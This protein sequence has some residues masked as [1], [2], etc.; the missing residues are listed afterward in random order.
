MY[1]QSVVRRV[2][3]GDEV[4]FRILFEDWAEVVYGRAYDILHDG[5]MAHEVVKR[6][7]VDVYRLTPRLRDG[8]QFDE[9]LRRLVAYQ[10]GEVALQY[11]TLNE[12]ARERDWMAIAQALDIPPEEETPPVAMKKRPVE[13]EEWEPI[14]FYPE[15][16]EAEQWYDDEEDPPTVSAVSSSNRAAVEAYLRKPA[17]AAAAL[18]GARKSAPAPVEEAPLPIRPRADKPDVQEVP[19]QQPEKKTVRSR[20]KAVKEENGAVLPFEAET[21]AVKS[22]R[23]G[24]IA[25]ASLLVAA[26]VLLAGSAVALILM[27]SGRL[28]TPSFLQEASMAVGGLWE[29]I[30]QSL[31]R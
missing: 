2:M 26:T 9:W 29:E 6:T 1:N 12:Q 5:T 28:G 21:P 31:F 30:V 16:D 7:F 8:R 10:C 4:A 3:K 14:L 18:R 20:K 23:R 25:V 11:R 15:E 27:H 17:A 13:E 22:R 19:L 24:E